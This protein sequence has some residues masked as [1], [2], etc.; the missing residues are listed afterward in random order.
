MNTE[1]IALCSEQSCFDVKAELRLRQRI[2]GAGVIF[3]CRTFTSW[4]F[5]ANLNMGMIKIAI[6]LH[7]MVSTWSF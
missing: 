1:F 4:N 3:L 2:L 7:L 5:R 6:E